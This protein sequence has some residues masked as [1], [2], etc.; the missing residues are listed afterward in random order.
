MRQ[1]SH[2]QLIDAISA[3]QIGSQTIVCYDPVADFIVIAY[4]LDVTAKSLAGT[5][6]IKGGA[7][8]DP[9]THFPLTT[10]ALV[11]PAG[12]GA[13]L[14]AGVV[15]FATPFPDIGTAY[16]MLRVADP[17]PY[18]SVAYVYTTGGGTNRFRVKAVY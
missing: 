15:T 1:L 6:T 18:V 12:T 17:P 4:R 2:I 7:E 3:S 11:S 14:S 8:P 13:T 16:A 9:A 10:A 5:L